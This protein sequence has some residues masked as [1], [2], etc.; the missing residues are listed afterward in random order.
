MAVLQA[1][2]R[3]AATGAGL[4]AGPP[5]TVHTPWHALDAEEVQRRPAGGDP[6]RRCVVTEPEPKPDTSDEEERDVRHAGGGRTSGETAVD[7]DLGR[8]D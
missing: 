5:V 4:A 6:I 3:L 1:R 8:G 7:D 2:V